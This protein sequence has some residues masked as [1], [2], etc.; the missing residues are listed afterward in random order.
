MYSNVVRTDVYKRQLLDYILSEYGINANNICPA[1]RGFYAETWK[2][3]AADR[4][5]FVKIVYQAAHK[6]VYKSS[7]P[8]IDYLNRQGIDFV[9]RIVKTARGRL[10]AQFDGA[11]LSIFDWIDGE[12]RQ[13][14]DTKIIEYQML[15]KIYTV[16]VDGL[17]IPCENFSDG[18]ADAFFRQWALLPPDASINELF[19]QRRARIEHR[20]K[21]LRIFSERC[22]ND[23][24]GFYITHGDA[25]GNFMVNGDKYYIVDW[26]T[27]M[28]APPERDAWVCMCW[29][30]ARDAY[31][32]ALWHNGIDYVLRQERLAYYC[33][34]M[35][36]YY[37][38]AYLDRF[39][40][41]GDTQGLEEYMDGW[42]EESFKYADKLI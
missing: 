31:H 17:V 29:D 36:F 7:L 5:Y 21:R 22:Q 33:Y 2:L 20:A 23:A 39:T 6:D 34:H 11:V 18:S 42:I 35:Y 26:D 9:G 27:P 19:E 40:H 37:L 32:E 12:N 14:V 30:W 13:D 16:P 10:S 28:L 25:G 8:V 4:S 24:S 3:S 38:N 1:R 15:A 41:I